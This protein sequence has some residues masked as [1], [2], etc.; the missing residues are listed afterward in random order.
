MYLYGVAPD[1]DIIGNTISLIVIF[2]GLQ[3]QPP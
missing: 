2:K 1:F 3:L